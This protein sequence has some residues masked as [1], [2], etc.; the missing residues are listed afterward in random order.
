MRNHSSIHAR[1][2]SNTLE[3][4]IINELKKSN[5]NLSLAVREAIVYAQGYR[6][7]KEHKLANREELEFL[8]LKS[9]L[10]YKSFYD[11]NKMNLQHE[12]I[13]L[14][15]IHQFA[16]LNTEDNTQQN[17]A[18]TNVS[19]SN[20]KNRSTSESVIQKPSFIDS[21]LPS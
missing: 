4:K 19:H 8:C 13:E 11:L 20:D 5:F 10:Y 7:C 12:G 1:Y 14:D 2:V 18:R 6:I 21:L 16:L 15:S 3:G 17:L 9:F